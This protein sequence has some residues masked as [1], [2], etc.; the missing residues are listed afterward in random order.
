MINNNIVNINVEWIVANTYQPRKYF[1]ENSLNELAQSI[2]NYGIMQPLSVR[3]IGE[4]K[5]ELI[6]GERRLRAA[7][8][9]GLELVPVIIN[10]ISDK[11]SAALA[12]LEN[13]QREDLNFMEESE[14]YYNLIKEHGYTQEQ[15][16]TSIGKK[17]STISN[18]LRLLKLNKSIR[19]IILK[20]SLTE[21]HARALLKLPD[22]EFQ[23][24]ILN[25]IIEKDLN[26]KNTEELI[27]KELIK[28]ETIELASDGKKRIK[29]IFS[30]KVYINTIKQVFDKYG[31]SANYRSKELDEFIEVTIKIK[32]K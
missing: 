1:D 29:G 21:R 32:K 17:Q 7:K 18:K 13:L 25:I 24:K 31:I 14:A 28:L 5:Y 8:I 4:N 20:N 11:E 19:D 9:V 2:K 6:A 30:P 27:E 15:L 10:N 16:A 22:E 23:K 3:N 26:V 12:L